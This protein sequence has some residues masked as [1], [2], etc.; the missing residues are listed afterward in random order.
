MSEKIRVLK[1]E[2]DRISYAW[3]RVSAKMWSPE[4]WES[5][6]DEYN[7]I[8]VELQALIPARIGELNLELERLEKENPWRLCYDVVGEPKKFT[9]AHDRINRISAEIAMLEWYR[10]RE[11]YN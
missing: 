10:K 7:R 6:K 1:A 3:T 5:S 2:L 11:L 4:Q 8:L 9:D